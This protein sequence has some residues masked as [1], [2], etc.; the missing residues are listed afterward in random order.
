MLNLGLHGS[1]WSASCFCCFNPEKRSQILIACV[2][3]WASDM[4]WK[5]NQRNAAFTCWV[6]NH[7]SL[8]CTPWPEHRSDWAIPARHTW[9]CFIGFFTSLY[10]NI[11]DVEIVYLHASASHNLKITVFHKVDILVK[12]PNYWIFF[13]VFAWCQNFMKVSVHLLSCKRNRT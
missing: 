3:V 4:V 10:V 8:L 11:H 13:F 7:G 1:E 2:I 6:L 9:I 12:L 5:L